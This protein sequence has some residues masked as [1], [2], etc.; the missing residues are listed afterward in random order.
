MTHSINALKGTNNKPKVAKSGK[1]IENVKLD[2]MFALVLPVTGVHPVSLDGWLLLGELYR[3]SR[4][5]RSYLVFE[6]GVKFWTVHESKLPVNLWNSIDCEIELDQF[7]HF[8]ATYHDLGKISTLGT[9]AVI[10]VSDSL[11][12]LEILIGMHRL[13]NHKSPN[14]KRIVE[15]DGHIKMEFK[16]SSRVRQNGSL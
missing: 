10:L 4:Q 16:G 13:A 5:T 15:C 7:N 3:P 2:S 8:E 14:L 12:G 11:D 1:A 9:Q 6:N